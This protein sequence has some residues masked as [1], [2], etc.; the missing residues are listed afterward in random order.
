MNMLQKQPHMTLCYAI[1]TLIEAYLHYL[2]N[3]MATN[4][5]TRLP[6]TPRKV[7]L[8]PTGVEPNELER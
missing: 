8:K 5:T 3:L 7:H 6:C 4:V 1:P 2:D